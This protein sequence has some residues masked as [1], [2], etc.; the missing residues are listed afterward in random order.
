MWDNSKKSFEFDL[1]KEF[2]GA[3]T[4]QY[5]LQQL[6][7]LKDVRAYYRTAGRGA[8]EVDFIVDNG[9]DVIPIEVKAGTNLQAKSLKVYRGKFRPELS[10]RMSM[11]DYKREDR[12][13]NLPLWAIETM[14]AL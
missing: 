7:T 10:I 3:L 14:A 12:L 13:L 11:E 1:F 9:S 2:K 6:K 4:E 8:A 5:V